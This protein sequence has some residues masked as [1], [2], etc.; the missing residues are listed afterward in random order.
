MNK[1]MAN[2]NTKCQFMKRG[3]LASAALTIS[4]NGLMRLPTHES[5]IGTISSKPIKI[6][7]L[8]ETCYLNPQHIEYVP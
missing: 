5:P 1:L 6:L 4:S 8:G 7:I 3:L 2:S